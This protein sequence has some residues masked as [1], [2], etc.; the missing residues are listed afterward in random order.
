[1][2]PHT[3]NILTPQQLKNGA[4]PG[5]VAQIMNPKKFR[6]HF[7][8]RGAACELR[9]QLLPFLRTCEQQGC[10]RVSLYTPDT[11]MQLLMPEKVVCMICTTAYSNKYVH[12]NNTNSNASIY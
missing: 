5:S 2:L 12:E 8:S 11:Y 3:S 4:V 10:H 9:L 6:I 1:M 7:I